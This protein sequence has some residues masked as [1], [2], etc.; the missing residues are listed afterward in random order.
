MIIQVNFTISSI[1]FREICYSEQN[2]MPK[3]VSH[4]NGKGMDSIAY[5]I[6]NT[7]VTATAHFSR[8]YNRAGP[9]H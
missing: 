6:S 5:F 3:N 9:V 2:K 7:G 1:L 4:K 8:F